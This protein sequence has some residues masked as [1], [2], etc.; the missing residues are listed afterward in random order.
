MEDDAVLDEEMGEEES[1]D[2]AEEDD[3]NDSWITVM[4]IVGINVVIGLLGF[5][6]FRFWKKRE[7]Q[8]QQ[9]ILAEMEG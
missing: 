5:F 4:I 8:K 3:G 2:D 9:D 6:G 1:I 7:Q